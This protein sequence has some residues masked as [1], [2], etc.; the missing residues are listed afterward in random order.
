ME[1]VIKAREKGRGGRE[2]GKQR[3]GRKKKQQV[4][5]TGGREEKGTAKK[6]KK[7]KTRG[8]KENRR[9]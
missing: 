9:K 5:G 4:R 3:E 2:G 7:G 6:M 1:R 8:R